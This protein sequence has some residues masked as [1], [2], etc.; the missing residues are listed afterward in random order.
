VWIKWP[1]QDVEGVPMFTGK[2]ALRMRGMTSSVYWGEMK[3]F[4][5]DELGTCTCTCDQ[6]AYL[7]PRDFLLCQTVGYY[8]CFKLYDLLSN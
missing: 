8:E 4:R 2:I 5:L 6:V 3:L 1:T 7:L